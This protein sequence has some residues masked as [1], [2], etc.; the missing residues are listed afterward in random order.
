MIES[1]TPEVTGLA[2]ALVD[3]SHHVLHL[4]NDVGR[5]Y[6]LTQQQAE[7]VCAVITRGRI[8]MGDLGKV[9]HL[10]KSNLSGLVDRVEQRGLIHRIQDPDDRRV[11]WVELTSEGARLA[12]QTHG[13][14]TERLNHLV[15]RLSAEDQRRL[16]AVVEQITAEKN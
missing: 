16:T 7:L 2:A 5:A 4:F 9:L 1:E 15:S 13:D 11:T 12:L 8:G 3:L 14:V 10:P 6:D